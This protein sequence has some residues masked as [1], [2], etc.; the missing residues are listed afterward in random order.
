VMP[1]YRQLR[2]KLLV[3]GEQQQDGKITAP[4][5]TS[6]LEGHPSAAN[7]CHVRAPYQHS[8]TNHRLCRRADA[9]VAAAKR[10][11]LHCARLPC[12]RQPLLMRT[13]RVNV[14]ESCSC[15]LCAAVL[16]CRIRQAAGGARGPA[17]V[18]QRGAGHLQR[19]RRVRQLQC[20]SYSGQVSPAVFYTSSCTSVHTARNQQRSILAT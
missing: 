5:H 15:F 13:P 16:C 20:A 12:V 7:A 18:Q 6:A 2:K 14:N 11:K 19:K 1:K 10:F 4:L 9:A 8:C 17:G 3:L